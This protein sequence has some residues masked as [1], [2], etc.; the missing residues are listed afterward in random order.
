MSDFY[1]DL[2]AP[3]FFGRRGISA[4]ASPLGTDATSHA[5]FGYT[6]H[7]PLTDLSTLI[8]DAEATV[9]LSATRSVVY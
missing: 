4:Y 7:T 3:Y 2:S 9:L 5:V 1:H 6:L 8:D